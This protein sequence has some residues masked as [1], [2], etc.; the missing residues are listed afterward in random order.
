MNED[1]QRMRILSA[2]DIPL[3]VF[4]AQDMAKKAGLRAQ[5]AATLATAVSEL[6]TNIIKYAEHGL[7]T[8]QLVTHNYRSGVEAIVKD[9]GPGI[10]DLDMAMKDHVSSSGTLGLGLPGTR[11]MVDEFEIESTPGS[12]TSVRIVVWA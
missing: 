5:K 11:R 3:A 8:V 6:A 4:L 12:G 9:R 7:L 1:S 2:R 10:A